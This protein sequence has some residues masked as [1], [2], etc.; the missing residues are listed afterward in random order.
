AVQEKFDL[1][2]GIVAR[3]LDLFVLPF[4]DRLDLVGLLVV[5]VEARLHFLE[6][7]TGAFPH[8][9]GLQSG[10]SESEERGR[11]QDG[12][13]GLHGFLLL[14]SDVFD[15][16]TNSGKRRTAWNGPGPASPP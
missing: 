1:V 2:V 16:C 3:R 10:A 9:V 12:S 5:Q 4:Q 11:E 8:A 7:L 13:G 6:L 15:G 14:G